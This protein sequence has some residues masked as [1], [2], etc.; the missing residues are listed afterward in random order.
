MTVYLR[1][2]NWHLYKAGMNKLKKTGIESSWGARIYVP[3]KTG[4]GAHPASYTMYTGSFPGVKRPG[5]GVDHPPTYSAEVKERVDLYVRS[6]SGPS[7]PVL[8]RTWN[9]VQP[10]LNILYITSE[11]T[12]VHCAVCLG[13]SLSQFLFTVLCVWDVP[14]VNCSS[15]CCVF[16]T[17]PSAALT[18]FVQHN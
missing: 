3:V 16:G 11:P 1:I 10:T 8:G 13:R 7:W 15:L 14:W 9:A 6:L 17:L 12:V 5:S 18:P 2:C 4:L